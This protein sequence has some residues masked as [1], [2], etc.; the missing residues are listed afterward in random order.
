MLQIWGYK[1]KAV[2]KNFMLFLISICSSSLFGSVSE[3]V[4]KDVE[5]ETLKIQPYIPK[6]SIAPIRSVKNGNNFISIVINPNGSGGYLCQ[7]QHLVQTD[8]TG[9]SVIKE[10]RTFQ[11]CSDAA[12]VTTNENNFFDSTASVN[13]YLITANYRAKKIFIYKL[14]ITETG[15]LR[16]NGVTANTADVFETPPTQG[17]TTQNVFATYLIAAADNNSDQ[18]GYFYPEVELRSCQIGQKKAGEAWF[19]KQTLSD[20]HFENYD[21]TLSGNMFQ[22]GASLIDRNLA[23]RRLGLYQ[24]EESAL[25]GGILVGTETYGTKYNLSPTNSVRLVLVENTHYFIYRN[26][27]R[28]GNVYKVGPGATSGTLVLEVPFVA[29]LDSMEFQKKLE[30]VTVQNSSQGENPTVSDYEDNSLDFEAKPSPGFDSESRKDFVSN[31]AIK[32]RIAIGNLKKGIIIWIQNATT[33]KG[34]S[35]AILAY[36]FVD[37]SSKNTLT[38]ESEVVYSMPLGDDSGKNQLN[39]PYKQADEIP[40]EALESDTEVKEIDVKVLPAKDGEKPNYV[41]KLVTYEKKS[42]T[43]STELLVGSPDTGLSP[44][45]KLIKSCNDYAPIRSIGRF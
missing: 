24:I 37:L 38:K 34:N 42:K 17:D 3:S 9:P 14:T 18:L 23:E 31:V 29:S 16:V 28:R 30:M 27:L 22:L 33:S 12:V 26:P 20:V 13:T 8:G 41:V 39:S 15:A 1:M 32:I 21:L 19:V 6:Q 43:Y 25:A 10:T 44:V 11:Y 36:V 45:D 40:E 5:Q 2:F 35:V 4:F 7:L